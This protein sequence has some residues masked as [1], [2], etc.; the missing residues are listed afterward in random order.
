[1]AATQTFSFG[2]RVVH[3]GMPEWGAGEVLAAHTVSENGRSGQ[4]LRIRF[5]RA[6][7]KTLSTIHAD[8]RP[9]SPPALDTDA[10]RAHA[11]AESDSALAR[12]LERDPAE[13][14]QSLP[15]ATSDPFAPLRS[16][17][18]ATLDLYRFEPTGASLI[19]WAAAQ[20]GLA[21]P[22]ARFNRHEL[23]QYFDRFQRQR[24]QRLKRLLLEAKRADPQAYQQ[25]LRQP[26]KGAGEVV[27]RVHSQG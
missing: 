2:D 19:D 13:V 4:R 5:E 12:A 18:R 17:L 11:E 8:I 21:D 25:T 22:L 6:G 24:D 26:P 27:R 16:R 20:S 3:A 14:F 7:L 1:M 15:E 23:E 10:E 9:A